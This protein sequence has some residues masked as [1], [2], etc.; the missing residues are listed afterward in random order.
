M[1][2]AEGRLSR[3]AMLGSAAAAGAVGAGLGGALAEAATGSRRRGS[4]DDVEHVVVL[5][6]ENRSFDHYYGTMAGVRGYGDRARLRLPGGADVY[7]QPDA[8][9][10]DG[11]QMLPFHVDTAL[12]D[13]QDLGELPHDWATTHQAWAN[14]TYN[15]WIAAKGEMTMSYFNHEDLPF[16]RAL[17]SAF[18]LC[19]NYF[20]SIQGPT[21]PNRLYHLT[22]TIDPDGR[23]GGPAT[24]N[25]ADYKPVYRWTTYPERLQAAGISWQ[26]YAND[27]IGD[28][29]NGYLGDYGDNPLWLFQAYHDALGSSDPRKRQLAE[30]ASLRAQWKP[31]SGKGKD[32]D[33]V[34]QQFIADCKADK[35]PAVSWVVAPYAYC[36]H[37]AA[38]PVD[39]AAYT[40]RVLKALWDNPKLWE[41]TVVLINYDENDGFFDHLV[42]PAA[43]PGTPGELVPVNQPN[44][45]GAGTGPLTPIGL[46]PRVPMTVI[47]PW[48]RGGWVNSQVFDHTSV[49]RFLEV[50]TGVKEPNISA[51]RRAI[52][53]DLTSCFDFS[54]R[55]RSIPKLPDAN[56]L[57]AEADRTQS[58]LPKP[59]T[60]PVGQQAMPEQEPG[61]AQARALP[62]QPAAYVTV[63]AKALDLH[64]ANQGTAALQVSAYAYHADG[65]SQRFDVG[66]GAAVAEKIPYSSGYDV[67]VHGPN[68]F[69]VEASGDTSTAGVDVAAAVCGS[70]SHPVFAL[71]VTNTSPRPATITVRGRPGFV[72]APRGTHRVTFDALAGSHG[73]YD[74]TLALVGYPA[75]HRRF[76]GHLENGRPSRTS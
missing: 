12:V 69:L 26:V 72:V 27:E 74:V 70:P 7:H 57:R 10:T 68:G 5:M 18:T 41:S 33:H 29:T 4:L 37:P 9:R 19:D 42:P 21:T 16:H 43:A 38:R 14:G 8:K 53:G 47:S 25:S 45:P 6:Q 32:V 15:A 28:G 55:D 40:Q 60:P 48:S 61:T 65:A 30:R 76:A 22:G 31:D 63:G 59:T 52:C 75:W 51:W 64:A 13:G 56:A 34:L 39:G 44:G 1:G 23:L 46:G 49:L 67:A 11:G 54:R 35:L 20:C 50:W 24:W 3:R 17:A 66:P 62:Y 71:T 2:Q 58:K 36:E 73:W